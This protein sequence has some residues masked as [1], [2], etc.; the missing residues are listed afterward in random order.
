MWVLDNAGP[1]LHL[2]PETIWVR[3]LHPPG[4]RLVSRSSVSG[5]SPNSREHNGN[6][7]LALWGY[8][9]DRTSNS[10]ALFCR[11]FVPLSVRVYPL[12]PTLYI[13]GKEGV[14]NGAVSWPPGH[15]A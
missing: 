15:D 12:F 2:A 8:V 6:I 11:D 7:L 3:L 14:A 1:F 10:M 13:H 4:P 5:A 9:R